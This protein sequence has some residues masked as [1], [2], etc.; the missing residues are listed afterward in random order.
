[1]HAC[2]LSRVWL[3]DPVD[4][5]PPGTSVHR[6]LWARILEGVAM[7]SSRGSSQSR[8]SNIHLLCL[9]NCRRNFYPL[10]HLGSPTLGVV[11]NVLN[12]RRFSDIRGRGHFLS[13]QHP[14]LWISVEVHPFRINIFSPCKAGKIVM[15]QTKSIKISPDHQRFHIRSLGGSVMFSFSGQM[16]CKMK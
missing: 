4:Y 5:S 6:I 12:L 7:L 15:T 1:M 9:L 10:S 3:C 2:V 16:T 13:A 14:F 8:G 11:L